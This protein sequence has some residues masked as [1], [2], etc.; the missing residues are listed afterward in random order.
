MKKG[1]IFTTALAMVLGVGAAVCAYKAPAKA[2][3]AYGPSDT[4]WYVAGSFNSWDLDDSTA[5][6]TYIEQVGNDWK[7]VSDNYIQ[8]EK[9]DEFKIVYSWD[10][11][12]GANYFSPD[13]LT[14]ATDFTKK[15]NG[16]IVASRDIKVKFD[17]RIYGEGA[18]WTGLYW[19][20]YED[21]TTLVHSARYAVDSWQAMTYDG[22]FVYETDKTG[23]IYKLENFSGDPGRDV[24]FKKGA[25]TTI[26]PGASRFRTI[27]DEELENNLFYTNSN[28]QLVTLQSFTDETLY[29]FL[30]EDGGYDSFLTGYEANPTTYYFTR[31]Q[32]NWTGTPKVYLFDINNDPRAAWPGED[33]TFVDYDSN[34]QARFSFSVCTDRWTKCV[35]YNP[36]DE[37]QTVDITFAGYL[38]DGFYLDERDPSDHNYWKVGR[39]NYASVE[40]KLRVNGVLQSLTPSESQ[41]GGDV[42]LQLETDELSLIAGQTIAYEVDESPAA[43][44]LQAYYRNNG[45][46]DSGTMKVLTSVSARIYVKL[47]SDTSTKVFV[48]GISESMTQ[49]YHIFMNDNEIVQ[50][51]DYDGPVPEGFTGQ[52]YSEDVTFTNGDKFRLIDMNTENALPTPFAVYALDSSSVAGFSKDDNGYVNY[53]G[54]STY[55][56]RIFLKLK[57]GQDVVY[58]GQSDPASAAAK[59]YAI[60]FNT[61]IGAICKWDGTTDQGDLENEWEE[62]A[63]TYKALASEVKTELLKGSSSSITDVQDFVEKYDSVYAL[64]KV[65]SGWDLEDFLSR[66]VSNGLVKTQPTIANS[67]MLLPI[68]LIVAITSITAVGMIVVIRRRKHD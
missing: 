58:V 61:A 60:A 5:H 12:A 57:S 48:G 52:K 38:Q 14:N 23:Y 41:P 33:M 35:F 39:Y 15:E 31:N 10:S 32:G 18:S 65:G 37:D 25:S 28:Q 17:L 53:S 24:T 20:E 51:Y 40:R 47:M 46:N 9:D 44:S 43:A 56:A 30:Y 11:G 16:N 34:N 50:L 7:F 6:L 68:V 2:V 59:A 67:T 49:G 8:L 63:T 13:L 22:T 21:P 1:L 4:T 62:Q 45:Y 36:A 55:D 54:A 3:S 27:D 42:L 26:K 66:H 64:R 29:L 19:Q